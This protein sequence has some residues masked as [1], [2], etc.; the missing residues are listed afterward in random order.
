MAVLIDK[1]FSQNFG[2]D[3]LKISLVTFGDANLNFGD[4]ATFTI[5][6][7]KDSITVIFYSKDF[8]G[9][10]FDYAF[11]GNENSATERRAAIGKIA[12]KAL[13]IVQNFHIK[14]LIYSATNGEITPAVDTF[15][16]YFTR[17]KF[18]VI[19]GKKY[20]QTT[21]DSASEGTE[22]SAGN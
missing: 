20:E 2:K 6:E 14:T 15:I 17:L 7:K 18:E 8:E 9:F 16:T 5:N 3:S 13:K 22:T 21:N 12:G 1:I 10:I 19:G 4:T 11:S